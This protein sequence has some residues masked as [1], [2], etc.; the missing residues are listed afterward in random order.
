MLVLMAGALSGASQLE[1]LSGTLVGLHSAV[2]S[3]WPAVVGL[4]C[5]LS[6]VESDTNHHL[7]GSRRLCARWRSDSNLS[8]VRCRSYSFSSIGL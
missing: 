8:L 7:Y 1:A 2:D 5:P 3:C 6:L 4:V